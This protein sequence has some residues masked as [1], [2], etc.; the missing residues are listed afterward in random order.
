MIKKNKLSWEDLESIEVTPKGLEHINSL[1]VHDPKESFRDKKRVVESL[2]E[3]IEENN[4]EDFMI[5]LKAY[6][7][8][9][10]KWKM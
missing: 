9:N 1:P 10:N 3:C 4:A 8:I 5:I 7:R 6:I 2:L